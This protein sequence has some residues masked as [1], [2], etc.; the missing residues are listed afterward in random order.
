M[1][2]R[3]AVIDI[4]IDLHFIRV[5]ENLENLFNVKFFNRLEFTF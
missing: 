3:I 2:N 1:K 5:I 4:K